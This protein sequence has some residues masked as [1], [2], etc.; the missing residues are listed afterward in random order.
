M[1]PE[2]S[3][4]A[5]DV[6]HQDVMEGNPDHMLYGKRSGVHAAY[7]FNTRP[8]YFEILGRCHPRLYNIRNRS[9]VSNKGERSTMYI[10]I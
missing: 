10:E 9:D 8:Q 4:H 5:A 3:G 7:R 1:W 2:P 6:R